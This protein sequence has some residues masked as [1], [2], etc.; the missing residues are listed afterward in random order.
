MKAFQELENDPNVS[1]YWTG[2]DRNPDSYWY[3]DHGCKIEKFVDDGRVEI[4]NVMMAGDHYCKI[5]SEQYEVFMDRGWLAGCYR[6]CM[7]T[8]SDRII[9]ARKLLNSSY[10]QDEVS[11]RLEILRKKLSRYVELNNKL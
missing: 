5:T 6:V 3:L 11:N 10:D 8:Y 1:L 4:N 9:R 7:E 2:D